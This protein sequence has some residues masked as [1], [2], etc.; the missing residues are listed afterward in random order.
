MDIK[1]IK[2]RIIRVNHAGEYAAK[3][4]YKGQICGLRRDKKS[5][6][7][8]KEML[9]TELGH[10]DFFESEIKKN[11]TRPTLFLPIWKTIGFG[12]GLTT[13]LL[14]KKAAM[15]CTVAVEDVIEKHYQKQIDLM[16]AMDFDD[17]D[18][19]LQI[20]KIRQE[21][22]DHK[23]TGLQNDAKGATF[24][25]LMSGIIKFGCSVGIFVSKRV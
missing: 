23:D 17:K 6:D 22:I 18:L 16:A 20:K 9:Q 7:L 13:G 15:A 14:G 4:I 5:C 21:E 2:D 11:K 25:D 3:Y 12:L 10:L 19:Q 1:K 24:Y 8:A